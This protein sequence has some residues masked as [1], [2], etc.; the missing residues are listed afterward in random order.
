MFFY[1]IL[2]KHIGAKLF[3]KERIM[4][5]QFIQVMFNLDHTENGAL[6]YKS[7]HNKNLDFFALAGAQRQEPKLALDLFKQAFIED[8]NLAIRN[9]FYIRDVRGGQGVRSVF[10]ECMSWLLS[11]DNRALELLKY[12]PEYGSWKDIFA[13]YEP[14]AKS[15]VSKR[16]EDI[17]FEQIM[18]DEIDAKLNRP[19]SLCAKWFPLTNNTKNPWK[20]KVAKS[21]SH[22]FGG[23]AKT[24][25]RISK[26]R[27]YLKVVE[28]DICSGDFWKIEYPKVPSKS[29]LRNRPAFRKHDL[30]RFEAYLELVESG[31]EKINTKTLYPFEL[32]HKYISGRIQKDELIESMWKNLP[33]YTNGINAICMVDVSGSMTSHNYIPLSVAVSLGLYFAERNN[34]VFK[35][36]F[37]SFSANPKFVEIDPEKSMYA[38][39]WKMQSA[40]WGMNTDINRAFDIILERAKRYNVPQSDMP[41]VL[42]II[43]DMEFDEATPYDTTYERMVKSYAENGYEL[44]HI[45]FWNV[46]ARSNAVP[47]DDGKNENV[48][49]VS[50][51][52]PVAFKYVLEG[53]SPIEFMREV[54]DSP[55]YAQLNH[56]F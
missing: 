27:D 19:I 24:R 36:R 37:I 39:I 11:N 14:F 17:V 3:L 33:D 22:V 31:K 44:P 16:I 32:V 13:L 55:R 26:L 40:D 35:N 5:N 46:A 30:Y 49:L 23:P 54:L 47:I 29:M 20:L 25:K 42:Y 9:M 51:Y 52:S 15:D 43:S 10:Y 45:V 12:I 18:Q 41:N 56:I 28:R 7:T 21:L 1:L 8:P 34:S 2:P 4:E 50:G 48:T 6:R 38:N 53:K